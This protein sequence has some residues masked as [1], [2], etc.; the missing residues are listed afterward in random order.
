[1]GRLPRDVSGEEL[2]RACCRGLGYKV[3]RQ[4]GSHVALRATGRPPLTVPLHPI[5]APGTLRAICREAGITVDEL[6]ELLGR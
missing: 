3:D 1:M 4:R 6:V 5:L 2:V